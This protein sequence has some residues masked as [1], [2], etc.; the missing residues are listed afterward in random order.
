MHQAMA[1]NTS[2]WAVV[3]TVDEPPM[4]VAAFLAWHLSLGASEIVLYFDRPD[5]PAADLVAPLDR[6]RAIRCDAAHW[7]QLGKHRP[8]KHQ[9]RQV[10]N[11]TQTYQTI[12]ADWLFHCDADEFLWAPQTVAACLD[13]ADETTDCVVV[14]VAE[15]IYHHEMTTK[16]AFDGVFR[17]PFA[18]KP[19]MGR[20][21]F[22]DAYA[23]TQRGLTGHAIGKSFLRRGRPLTPSI[24]RPKPVASAELAVERTQA[25]ELLH[26]DGLTP[27]HWVYK[28]LRKVNAVAHHNGQAPSPHRQRQSDALLAD[29]SAAFALHDRLKRV[30][31]ACLHQL[32]ALDLLLEV[33]FSPDGAI[34]NVFPGLDIALLPKDVDDWIWAHKSAL[35]HDVVGDEDR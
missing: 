29:P 18:G 16:S 24:H 25:L 9:V 35:I 4:L 21:L 22:G 30:D 19:A 26:F 17:R 11:A 14:P 23:L 32:A 27:L 13:A 15:R 34:S 31:G 3:A 1:H 33:D 8:D 5:D 12:A 10:V 6:V 7:A 20:R 2:T 28:I